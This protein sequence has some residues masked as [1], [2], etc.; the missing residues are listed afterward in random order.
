MSHL[1]MSQ[2]LIA[3]ALTALLLIA[4]AGRGFAFDDEPTLA[5]KKA[6]EWMD[7]L[8]KGETLK[9][10]RAGAIA[11]GVIGPKYMGVVQSLARAM[12]KDPE[13]EVRQSCRDWSEMIDGGLI[14]LLPSEP[15]YPEAV[16]L[17]LRLKHPFQDCLYLA[18]AER[19]RAPLVT[20][21]P[22]FIERT[23]GIYPTVRPLVAAPKGKR[24]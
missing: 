1:S 11:L 16:A 18:L 7:L 14:A 20:A 23:A 5:G 22:K 19:L 9:A 17:A 13:A 15:D 24:H 6:S 3:L 2:R 4:D 8:Q 12:R 10:R 21:D